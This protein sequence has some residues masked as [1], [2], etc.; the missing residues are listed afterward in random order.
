M[1]FYTRIVAMGIVEKLSDSGCILTLEPTGFVDEPDVDCVRCLGV[2]DAS[3]I[4][5]LSNWIYYFLTCE[6]LWK[7]KFGGGGDGE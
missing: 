6:E 2:K 7:T 1:V 5:D 3:S 4:F